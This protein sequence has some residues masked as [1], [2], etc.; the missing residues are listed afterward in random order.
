M[1]IDDDPLLMRSKERKK[2][3]KEKEKEKN[4]EHSIE[5]LHAPLII[6]TACILILFRKC[7]S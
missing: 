3:E 2:K 6:Q 5:R 4:S 7:T 1:E